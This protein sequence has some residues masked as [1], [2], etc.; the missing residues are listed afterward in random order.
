[1]KTIRNIINQNLPKNWCEEIQLWRESRSVPTWESTVMKRAGSRK[2]SET[3]QILYAG[4]GIV[5]YNPFVF[6]DQSVID[7][8]LEGR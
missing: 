6:I 5:D 8:I 3:L 1:M 2:K 7:Q 4:A